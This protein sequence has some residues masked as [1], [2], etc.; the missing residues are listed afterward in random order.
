MLNQSGRRMACQGF[1]S[2]SRNKREVQVFHLKEANGFNAVQSGDECWTTHPCWSTPE[3]VQRS[4][5]FSRW[6]L[7][8][9]FQQ[10]SLRRCWDS[11]KNLPEPLGGMFPHTGNGPLQHTDTWKQYLA[12]NKMRHRQV[13]EHRQAFFT[14]PRTRVEPAQKTKVLWLRGEI[15]VAILGHDFVDMLVAH[16]ALPIAREDSQI[17]NIQL[18]SQ[19]QDDVV[20][21]IGW[22]REK[23]PQEPNGTQLEGKAQTGMSMPSR[24]QQAAITIIEMKVESQLLW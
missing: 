8:Q 19:C 6:N 2:S 9:R 5:P 24:L 23:R 4:L 15:L 21:N 11:S 17:S 3:T 7:Q 16:L 1:Q 12:V 22:I 10:S 18:G 20:R 13:K 14:P